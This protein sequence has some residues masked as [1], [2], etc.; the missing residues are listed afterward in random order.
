MNYAHNL[1]T[2]AIKYCSNIWD[3]AMDIIIEFDMP[4]V[5]FLG[6]LV[7]GEYFFIG[8]Q[9]QIKDSEGLI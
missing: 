3:N 7:L 5:Q 1:V 6:V 2:Y 4:N 9:K 8:L